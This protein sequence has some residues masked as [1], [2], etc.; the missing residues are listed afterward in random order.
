MRAGRR[1]S[2]LVLGALC[3]IVV[4]CAASHKAGMA[5]P[6]TAPASMGG[7]NDAHAQIEQLSREIEQQRTKLGVVPQAMAM[8]EV[9]LAPLSTE[10]AQCHP[11]PS[12][13]CRD[14]CTVSD[15]ICGNAKKICDLAGQL[16]GDPWAEGKC[17]D[18]KQTCKG[19]HDTC[20]G[21]Q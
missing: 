7:G 11:A 16:A 2:A 21:C 19:A 15:S 6:P 13:T 1:F 17:K 10:D 14:S 12:E 9:P 4:A 20:C 3:A 8:G 5:P 18:A